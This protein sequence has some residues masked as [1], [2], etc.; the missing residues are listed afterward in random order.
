MFSARFTFTVLVFLSALSRATLGQANA[1]FEDPPSN[2]RPK[3]RYWLPDA[4]I[5]SDVVAKDIRAAK[6]A[7]AGGLEILPFY[8]YGRGEESARRDGANP[9]PQLPD[10]SKYGFG[11]PAFVDLFRDTLETAEEVG[12]LVDYALGA[13]QGQ[14]VPSEV[15]TP[16]LAVE[17]LMGQ[18]TVAPRG[19]FNAHV[20]RAQQPSSSILSGLSFMHPLEQFGTPNLT[21]V[22]AYQVEN[23]IGDAKVHLKQSSFIDL[24]S[25]VAKNQSLQWSPPT[26]NSTWKIFSFWEAYTNQ[27]SCDAGPKPTDFLGNGS[28]TVDHFS[29][30]G[31]SRV[32]DFWDKYILSDKQ[33]AGLLRN[34]G[35]YE[36]FEDSNGYDLLPYLPLLFSMS[37]TWNGALPVYNE[38][39][40]FG[41]YTKDGDSIYQLDYRKALNDGYQQYLAHFQQWTHSVGTE[42]STQ[43]AYNLP[44]QALSDIALIDAPEGESLGFSQNADVYRQFAGPAHL[45]DKNV[46]STEL[47]AVNTPP[48]WLTIPNLL[49]QIKRSF[50]GGFT[51]NVIHGFPTLTPYPNTTWPGYTPFTYQFTEMWNQ[52][53]PAWQHIKDSLDYVGRNQWVLQQGQPKVD[54]ALYA[55]AAPWTIVTRYDS[56]NLRHWG[57]Y[58]ENLLILWSLLMNTGFS[59]DYLGPDNL[60]SSDAFVKNNKLG[61]PE[62]KALIFSNQTIINVKA[63]EALIEFASQGLKLIFV[64]A[65]PNQSYPTDAASQSAVNSAMKRL[66]AGPNIYRIDSV[67]QLPGYQGI[68]EELGIAPRVR[69]GCTPSSIY[70]MYRST[71]QVDY[72]YLF[73]DQNV[74][75]KC[76]VTIEAAGVVPY[77]YDAW[78]GSQSSLLQYSLSNTSIFHIPTL[79]ANETLI[80]A[81]QRSVPPP[82]CTLSQFS[83]YIRSVDASGSNLEVVVT[84]SPH[85]MTT[86]TNKTT[87]FNESIPPAANLTT[88]DLTVEDWHSAPDRFAVENEI[89]NHTFHNVSLV[90]WDQLSASL[91][92]VSGIGHYTVH[93]E[94]PN[95]ADFSKLMGFVNLPLIQHSA[96]VYLDGEWL[97]PIDPVNPVVTLKGLQKGKVYELRIDVS[98]TLFNRVK[99]EADQ[100]WMVGSIASEV[101]KYNSLPYEKYGLV[102]NVLLEWGYRVQVPC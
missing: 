84:Y 12:L 22:I 8:L 44:L 99:A 85:I 42:Y 75:P 82:V 95:D 54:L 87:R 50:G 55:Y 34:V 2:Y 19:S 33:V 30:A 83:S 6:E 76:G 14:G 62:Y 43:P 66:L 48:Y 45:A 79:K 64:G 93:F 98:T 28:W 17:L 68:L 3:F 38:T 41:N 47:G 77:V 20:P 56:D 69:L 29:K 101:G 35:K 74:Q 52:I 60:G 15:S 16:G 4:S 13:N 92:H 9:V 25:L 51:M 1:D 46:I 61:V 88:W 21:A 59:Y 27:R 39:Y 94:P 102:G 57:M 53:Q 91:A 7:G 72:V 65:P 73:N 100:V 80:L 11:T 18:E 26:S 96:R 90:P 78:T 32:T 70:T 58:P 89:M 81:L 10:W 86:S 63:A 31:A 67:E 5:P 71:S 36:R 23:N 40:I 49:Q 97:G 24:S 37:N